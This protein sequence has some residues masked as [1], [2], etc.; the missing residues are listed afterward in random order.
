MYITW[1]EAKEKFKGKWVVLRNPDW[2]DKFHM[3]L[4]GGELVG[5]ADDMLGMEA[6]VPDYDEVTQKDNVYLSKHTEEDTAVG[7]TYLGEFYHRDND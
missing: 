1:D 2:A 4:I 3:N 7:L 5:T 6:L